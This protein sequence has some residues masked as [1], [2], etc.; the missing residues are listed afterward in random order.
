MAQWLNVQHA[1]TSAGLWFES[2]RGRGRPS[3]KKSAPNW[4][5]VG[6]FNELGMATMMVVIHT[7]RLICR[8][9][10]L[11]LDYNAELTNNNGIKPEG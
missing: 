9:F 2:R 10:V 4:H 6:D 7:T 1:N 3:L 8:L 11:D 5:T